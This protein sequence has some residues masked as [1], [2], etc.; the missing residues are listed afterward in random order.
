MHLSKDN[1]FI[2]KISKIDLKGFRGVCYQCEFAVDNYHDLLSQ[3]L[4]GSALPATLIPVTKTRKADYLAGR[5]LARQALTCIG[6]TKFLVGTAK[7]KSPVW[8]VGYTGS[9]SHSSIYAICA[10]AK[11]DDTHRV[12]LD[13]QTLF[14]YE[15]MQFF[16]KTIITR[17]E[18][19]LLHSLAYLHVIVATIIFSAKESLFKALY[20]EV[21]HH[22]NFYAAK[23]IIIDPHYE[24]FEIELLQEL[25]VSLPKGKHFKGIYKVH[26]DYIF[27]AI[28]TSIND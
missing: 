23:V 12:G 3:K 1:Y 13:V 28:F 21:G 2:K 25:S 9:I 19:G 15:D 5:F 14:T 16:Y 6:S 18:Y 20:P 26:E 11:C 8:P 7:D 24:V 27:T 22:F 10:V 4:V 17:T